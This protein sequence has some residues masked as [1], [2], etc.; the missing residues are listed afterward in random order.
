MMGII[1]RDL[2]P[3]NVLVRANG[4]IMLTDFDLSLKDDNSISKPQLPIKVRST[5]FVGTHEYVAPEIISGEGHGNVVDWW[6]LGIF[7]FELLYGVTPFKGVDHE[8]TLGNIVARALEFHKEPSVSGTAK[9]L[10]T[11][12][13]IK[14]PRRRMGSTM[15][16]TAIKHHFFSGVNWALLRCTTPPYVPR[17]FSYRDFIAADNTADNAVEYY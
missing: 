2:K 16:A 12:L 13:L 3:E 8:L 15:G 14:D 4:H 5:S 17:P 9:D 1:Y 11:R 10:I 7:I 6:T